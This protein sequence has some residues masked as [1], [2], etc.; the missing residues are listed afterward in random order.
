MDPQE[1]EY[2]DICPYHDDKYEGQVIPG[3]FKEQYCRGIY[4][5]CGRYVAYKSEEERKRRIAQLEGG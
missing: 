5:W 1:C 4:V 3:H 2:M